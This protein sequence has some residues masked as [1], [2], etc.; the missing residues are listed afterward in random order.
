MSNRAEEDEFPVPSLLSM[1][2]MAATYGWSVVIHWLG[3]A[4]GQT[5]AR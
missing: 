2:L 1:L 3:T 4:W 5:R